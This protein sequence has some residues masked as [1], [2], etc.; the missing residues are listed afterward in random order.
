MKRLAVE[1]IDEPLSTLT[2]S[3]LERS[4]DIAFVCNH[5]GSRI[6]SINRRASDLFGWGIKELEKLDSW[7]LHIFSE[8]AH[9]PISNA[10]RNIDSTLENASGDALETNAMTLSGSR[11]PV[12]VHSI[13]RCADAIILL[14]KPRMHTA[15]AEEILRQTQARFRSIVDSL[16]IHLILKDPN[17]KRIY[18]N[19]TYLE[20]RAQQLGD[21]I[22]K[23]DADLFPADLARAYE[24]DD[25]KVIETGKIIHKFEESVDAHGIRTWTEVIKGPLHDADGQITGI[26][27]LFWDA[28]KRKATELALERERYLLRALLNNVPDSIYFKD[29]DSRFLRI[30]R[31]MAQKFQLEHPKVAIGKTDADIFSHDHAAQAREDELEIMDTG[32]PMIARIE[33]E[34]WPDKGDTWCSTTKLPLRDAEG[35]VVGTFGISRDMT[36]V[37]EA[38]QMLREAKDAATKANQ[39]KS[40]FLANMSHEIRTPM[41]GIIGM[42]ELLRNTSLT[43]AQ[44]SFLEM[45]DQSANSL[46]RI[47]NDI[48]D[49]SKVEAGK[50]GLEKAT[51]DLRKCVS[52]ATKSLAARASQKSVELILQL[53]PELPDQLIGDAG[54][55]RQVLVNLVGNAIKFTE[56]GEITIHVS[57]ADGPPT[58]TDYR[59]HFSVRDTGIGIPREKQKLIFEAFSQADVSTTRQYGGTGL[60][61]SISAQLVDL[62]NGRIWL[63]SEPGVGSTFHFTA[64]FKPHTSDDAGQQSD[65]KQLSELAGE[66]DLQEL[67]VLIIQENQA[68]R[69]VLRTSLARRGLN[70]QAVGAEPE[71]LRAALKFL[72]EER[73]QDTASQNRSSLNTLDLTSSLPTTPTRP[74]DSS[75]SVQRRPIVILDLAT[76]EKAT[77]ELLEY[78]KSDLSTNAPIT[79]L[80]SATPHPVFDDDDS[81]FRA[82]AILQK[83]A[84]HSEVCYAIKNALLPQPAPSVEDHPP[85]PAQP[86]RRLRLLLAE[87]GEVNRLVFVGLLTNR[88]H[89]VQCVEDGQ[90]A[91]DAWENSSF[92]AIFMDL[93]MPVLDGLEATRIIRQKETDEGN[94]IPIIAITAAAMEVDHDRCIKAGMDGYLSK[95]IDLNMLDPL[96]ASLEKAASPQPVADL[97]PL[98]SPAE[99]NIE[100]AV[101]STERLHQQASDLSNDDAR[102]KLITREPSAN[103]ESKAK[104]EPRPQTFNA[105]RKKG[106]GKPNGWELPT[107]PAEETEINFNAPIAKLRCTARQQHQLV[108]TL[109]RETE[110]RLEEMSRAIETEDLRLLVRASHSLKSASALFEAYEVAKKSEIIE[111]AAR[112]GDLSQA[113]EHFTALRGPTIR[114]LDA[115]QQWLSE[116]APES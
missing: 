29:R 84:L 49:F 113:E 68:S 26:Q 97:Q 98:N 65:E 90:A 35:N 102:T 54:R 73:R 20:H 8:E 110:Q 103:V 111:T 99:N 42:A 61:L 76:K 32:K 48:L 63:E 27:I 77:F 89:S 15:N 16:S 105:S 56:D 82:D 109:Q 51:F 30:S 75:S 17:G 85:A 22:G 79:I 81:N 108:A 19:R 6:L 1:K 52:H 107:S 43:Q 72:K 104:R 57:L 39:A 10:F 94:R 114:M 93:Q 34:T 115:I 71:Q 80:L 33:R 86:T 83:P 59:L 5:D 3:L 53:E 46:L 106:D 66:V 70:V 28:T 96:L 100:P 95:P 41:N 2:R 47:I 21:V 9:E 112:A 25:K 18:A 116:G 4:S 69:E 23:S 101:A 88:G 64:E 87:D 37:I 13:V 40:E 11:L 62:M 24:A 58:S 36:Q 91:V 67:K 7:W 45:I 92:D 14:A 55:L 44:R 78:L 60:G 38:E 50:L 74:S 31:G 12:L